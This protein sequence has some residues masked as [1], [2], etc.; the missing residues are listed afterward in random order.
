MA[1]FSN[2][3]WVM[4]VL[5]IAGVTLNYVTR[6]TLG[7]L[8][9][10]L[11]QVLNISTQEYSWIVAAF[12]LAYTIFQP[13]CGWV[14]DHIGLKI[15]FMFFAG[16]WALVCLLHPLATNWISLAVMRFCMGATEAAAAPANVKFLTEWFPKKERGV[17]AGWSGVGFSLGAMLAPPLVIAIHLNYGWQAAFI[18]P[19]VMG[20]LWVILWKVY[21]NHPTLKPNLSAQEKAFVL[22]EE[23][24]KDQEV[25]EKLGCLESIKV[26][27]TTKNFLQN[28]HG[29]PLVSL[30][31]YI[32]PPKEA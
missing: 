14:L 16:A 11:K 31:L 10:E 22:D 25:Q 32:L 21:Y 24:L 20:V 6:N 30:F 7:V 12:Q 18:V 2:V 13:I 3:R 1:K 4:L 26:I 8:A 19:G 17:A 5:F 28:H 15:G 9:P 27:A 29:K 23:T